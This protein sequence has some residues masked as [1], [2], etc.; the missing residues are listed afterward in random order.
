MTPAL[1]QTNLST[2]TLLGALT[3]PNPAKYHHFDN[4]V[5]IS[6]G[7]ILQYYDGATL[8]EVS[9]PTPAAITAITYGGTT[10]TATTGTTAHNLTA[11]MEIVITGASP[12]VYNGTFIITSVTDYTFSYTL[13]STPTGSASPVGSYTVTDNRPNTD[14]VIDKDGRLQCTKAG[15][16]NQYYSQIGAY[17]TVAAWT[18]NPNDSSSAFTSSIG[19]KD[20]SSTVVTAA[21]S[22]DIMVFKTPKRAY[23][24]YGDPSLSNYAVYEASRDIDVANK[25]CVCV[26]DNNIFVFGSNGFDAIGTVQAYGSVQKVIPS[27]GGTWNSFFKQN[28]DSTCKIWN[29]ESRGQIWIRYNNTGN[30][31]VFHYNLG[32]VFTFRSFEN[33]VIDV[34]ENGETVYIAIGNG[35]Y[36]IDETSDT[37]ETKAIIANMQVGKTGGIHDFII[38]WY[39]FALNSITNSGTGV[40]TIPNNVNGNSLTATFQASNSSPIAYL[41]ETNAYLNTNP[42]VY[43]IQNVVTKNFANYRVS[44]LQPEVQVTSGRFSLREIKINVANG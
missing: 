3:G 15:D 35:I 25:N 16:D 27:V 20:S 43:P 14:M 18:N 4:K 26:T 31:A 6:S 17:K 19:Y 28:T 8:T 42:L 1:Y 10:A 37:T 13:L 21:L 38:S 36:A 2:Q 23:R 9:I 41:D 24:I 39:K 12:T 33:P 7:A 22:T 44:S 5:I 11:G 29:L 40:A 30:I 32:G 34:T